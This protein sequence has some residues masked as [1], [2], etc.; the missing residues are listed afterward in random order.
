MKKFESKLFAFAFFAK[1]DDAITYLA[2][3]LADKEEWDFSD[4]PKKSH[5]ILKNYIE[6]IFRKIQTEG[7]IA[8]TTDNSNACFNTGLVTKNLEPIYA[9][10]E[11]N[12][13][14]APGGSPYYFKAFVKESDIKFLSLFPNNHPEVADFFQNPGDLIFNPGCK[15]IPQMDHI[16]EDN[17]GRFPP[18]IQCLNE[19]ERRMRLSGAIE[20][21]KKKVKT[22]YKLAVPQYYGNRIQLLLPLCLTPNSPNPDLALAVHKISDDTY[23]ARTCLTL[24]MAY[25][26]ARLIVKPQSDWL[27]P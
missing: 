3:T 26:N 16:L 20:E 5:S 12:K 25:N 8:F 24:K 17:N 15:L 22:N 9:L 7:K 13:I 6:H 19:S 1:Y 10:F 23:T 4:A 18:H 11:T 14:M 21:V 27:K 2:E